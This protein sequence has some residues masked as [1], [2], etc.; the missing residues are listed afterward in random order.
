MAEFFKE[1]IGCK[2]EA[3]VKGKVDAECHY[4]HEN[5]PWAGKGDPYDF[6]KEHDEKVNKE[7]GAR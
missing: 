6:E 4:C 1:G 3:M 7:R 5:C 2:K